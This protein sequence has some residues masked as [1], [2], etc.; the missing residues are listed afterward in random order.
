MTTE[1]WEKSTA[2]HTDAT[3]K[4]FALDVLSAL[5]YLRSRADIDVDKIG[6]IGHSEGGMI[7]PKVANSV[8]NIA[9]IV[10]LGAT[11]IPGSEVSVHLAKINRGFPVENEASDDLAI[12]KAIKIASSNDA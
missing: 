7:A 6:L 12:R 3:T 11:G 9:F 10:L 2:N 8:K 1:G 5:K 4:D